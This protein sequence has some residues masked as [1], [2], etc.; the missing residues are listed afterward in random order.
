MNWRLM[1]PAPR[2]R[3]TQ[4]APHRHEG[5]VRYCAGR[6]PLCD[7]D[8]CQVHRSRVG[9][10]ALTGRQTAEHAEPIHRP[11]RGSFTSVSADGA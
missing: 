10:G 5:M 7:V 2:Q 9:L 3:D 8:V 11:T 1:L 4:P 6:R